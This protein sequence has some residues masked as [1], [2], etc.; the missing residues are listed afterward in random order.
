MAGAWAVSW[1]QQHGL[2]RHHLWLWL[3]KNFPYEAVLHELIERPLYLF[4]PWWPFLLLW[5]RYGMLLW[6]R[7]GPLYGSSHSLWHY[8]QPY[9]GKRVPKIVPNCQFREHLHPSVSFGCVHCCLWKSLNRHKSIVAM[10]FMLNSM[11]WYF[12]SHCVEFTKHHYPVILLFLTASQILL[13]IQA[14]VYIFCGVVCV[15]TG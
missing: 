8:S 11:W 3:A 14:L 15:K 2:A 10:C 13:A 4:N 12:Q 7:N 6:A 9:L 1:W 5:V